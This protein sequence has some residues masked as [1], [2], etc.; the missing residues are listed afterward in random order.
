MFTDE[1]ESVEGLSAADLAKARKRAAKAEAK[2]QAEAEAERV[3]AEEEKAAKL[4]KM[5]VAKAAKAAK[6][7]NRRAENLR[8][9]LQTVTRLQHENTVSIDEVFEILAVI[10]EHQQA[11]QEGEAIGYVRGLAAART[12]E[13][14]AVRQQAHRRAILAE[15]AQIERDKQFEDED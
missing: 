6:L 10:V 3:Q 5:N 11:G 9:M 1:V 14:Y 4:H 12:G 13:A 8:G 2:A 7:H 15:Q